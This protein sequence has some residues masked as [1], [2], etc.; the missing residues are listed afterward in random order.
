[1]AGQRRGHQLLS[2]RRA[3]VVSK[4]NATIHEL[5]G[6]VDVDSWRKTAPFPY[7]T[8]RSAPDTYFDK[9]GTPGSAPSYQSYTKIEVACQ[10]VWNALVE[11]RKCNEELHLGFRNNLVETDLT[12]QIARLN[13]M[14]RETCGIDDLMHVADGIDLLFRYRRFWTS[15]KMRRSAASAVSIL[16]LIQDLQKVCQNE[17]LVSRRSSPLSRV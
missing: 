15:E 9:N 4:T 16:G 1:M 8:M 7:D 10:N 14:H 11:W 12:N 6:D 17:L 13:R 2:P 5:R 3:T